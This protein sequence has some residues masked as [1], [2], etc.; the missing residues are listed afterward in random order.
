MSTNCA[1]LLVKST[2]SRQGYELLTVG[3]L[4]DV[5]LRR[6]DVR[7]VTIPVKAVICIPVVCQ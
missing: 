7:I 1:Y 5:G 4:S 6:Q 2:A 3:L